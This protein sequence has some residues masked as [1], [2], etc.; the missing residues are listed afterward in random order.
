MKHILIYIL[1]FWFVSASCQ[2]NEPKLKCIE[3]TSIFPGF[4]IKGEITKYDTS[5]IKVYF[6]GSK[7]M[8][9][10][11]YDYTYSHNGKLIISEVR[12]HYVAFDVDSTFG[13]DLNLSS[14]ITNRVKLDSLFKDE[15]IVKNKLY[16]II[17]SNIAILTDSKRNKDSG[18]LVENYLIKNKEDSADLATIIFSFTDKIS[19][20]DISLSKE[21]DSIMHMKL[22][23]AEINHFSRYYKENNFTMGRFVTCYSL[24]EGKILDEK[25]I[26]TYFKMLH[27]Y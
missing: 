19:G 25:K 16:P 27:A 4:T 18:T 22:F 9:D 13:Y 1:L 3:A 10:L 2:T 6:L 12:R 21:L 15:W 5:T 24:K 14:G 7:R 8:Y 11:L 20:I 26:L 23:N 17:Q